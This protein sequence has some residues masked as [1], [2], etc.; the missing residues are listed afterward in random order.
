MVPNTNMTIQISDRFKS[1]FD[2]MFP[3]W[4]SSLNVNQHEF[5]SGKSAT[6]NL[7]AFTHFLQG[8]MDQPVQVYA[9]CSD[10]SKAF[11]ILSCLC[12]SA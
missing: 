2:Q 12:K 1:A 10:Y 6:T 11:N 3:A 9:I 8:N 4:N 5:M 7:T